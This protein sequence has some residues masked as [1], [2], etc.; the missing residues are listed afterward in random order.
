MEKIEEVYDWIESNC[1]LSDDDGKII[2][3]DEHYQ[4]GMLDRLF[5]GERNSVEFCRCGDSI[6]SY[7]IW[8]LSYVV[9][10]LKRDMNIVVAT[11]RIHNGLKEELDKISV[12]M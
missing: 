11:P 4:K 10:H 7:Y 8:Y 5:C 2:Q 12:F 1:L 3:C 9:T 6:T